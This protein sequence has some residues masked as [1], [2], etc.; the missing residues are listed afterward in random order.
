MNR[1]EKIQEAITFS[2]DKGV[3]IIPSIVLFDWTHQTEWPRSRYTEEFPAICNWLGAILIKLGYRR[4]DV[5]NTH[6]ISFK[7]VYKYLETD[8]N[9]ISRF[10]AGFN[11]GIQLKTE[12]K[13]GKFVDEPISTLG[14]QLRK[15][16]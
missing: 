9:W 11:N 4:S 1:Q 8:S 3:K 14:L 6:P 12:I 5:N 16:Y 2:Q 15:K 10:G 7:E 13:K